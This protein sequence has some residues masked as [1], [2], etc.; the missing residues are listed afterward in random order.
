MN[1]SEYKEFK[2]LRKESLRD[3]MTDIEIATREL[4]KKYKPYGL[5]QNSLIATAGGDT[6]KVARDNLEQKLGEKIISKDNN[7][8]YQYIGDKEELEIK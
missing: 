8:S 7:L 1:A 5:A 6:A 3:N 2:G 4:A